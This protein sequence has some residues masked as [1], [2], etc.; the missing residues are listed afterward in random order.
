MKLLTTRTIDMLQKMIF[1][2]MLSVCVMGFCAQSLK[3]DEP[4]KAVDET[5]AGKAAEKGK[6][7]LIEEET[8]LCYELRR[9]PKFY[10]DDNTVHGNIFH[11]SQLLGNPMGL[12]DRLVDM[13]IYVD[14]GI[15]QFL[16]ANVSGGVKDGNIRNNGTADYWLEFDTGKA[17]LWSG[18][19]LFLHGETSWEADQS[20]NADV[21][22]LV[23]PN[24]DATMPVDKESTSTFSKFY[25]VQ[26]LPANCLFMVGRTDHT[27]VAD[28]NIFANDERNQ[29]SHTGLVNNPI[30]G[31]F[32]P[33]ATWGAA[34]I[35]APNKEHT[36]LVAAVATDGD[37]NTIGLK[38][39]FNGNTTYCFQYQYSPTI[40]GR[41]GNYRILP[42]YTSKDHSDFAIDKRRH[43]GQVL[44]E[45]FESNQSG[46]YTLMGN[47]DQYLWVK[48][49]SKDA[50][51]RERRLKESKYPGLARLELPPVGIGIFGRVGWAPKNRNLID[52]FYS[53]GV[54]GYGMLI[55]GRDHDRWGVGWSGTHISSDV[56]SFAR[57]I[58]RD[59]D[60]LE[61][62]FEAF[63]NFMVTPSTHLTMNV[64]V[65][66]ST[67]ESVD[68]ATAVGFRLQLDF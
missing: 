54:G 39:I 23:P 33:Y 5:P 19:S 20:I 42:L 10:G 21:G 47:F 1:A 6:M 27:G 46:N 4:A 16:G 12:R 40:A 41:P 18:G 55:P 2:L 29:F 32:V 49:G 24:F 45:S 14:V 67:L 28:Q 38:T 68:T 3:G 13:G 60:S 65:L 35:W 37:A 43:T 36:F 31:A 34:A 53:F 64:Q 63:Y 61:H 57:V 17:G 59:L 9:Y 44:G 15:T 48:G 52:Q 62:A 7:S 8:E 22:S 50:Y 25:M 58:R 30:L 66:D 56:R 11:R 26:E 51:H